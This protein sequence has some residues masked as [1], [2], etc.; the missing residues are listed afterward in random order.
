MHYLIISS[1][2][3]DKC[4]PVKDEW[5]GYEHD[6]CTTSNP[7]GEKQGGCKSNDECGGGYL[8]C[9]DSSTGCGSKFDTASGEK[10]CHIEG[11]KN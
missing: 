6:C 7:C 2:G 3:I 10:C 4:D 5:N 9:S 1:L 11:N 8:V